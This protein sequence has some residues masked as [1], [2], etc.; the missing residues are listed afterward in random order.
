[1]PFYRFENLKSYRFNPHLSTAEG[2]VIEGEFMYLYVKDRTWTL[3]GAAAD[4]ALPDTS[5]RYHKTPRIA[6]P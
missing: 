2:P 5:S 4:E 6:G 1:M 3:I